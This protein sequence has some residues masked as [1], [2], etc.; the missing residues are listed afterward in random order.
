[1]RPQVSLGGIAV[2]CWEVLR[3]V[4]RF[5]SR[6]AFGNCS[7][8]LGPLLF[9]VVSALQGGRSHVALSMRHV[10]AFR[11][12]DGSDFANVPTD[13]AL[14]TMGTEHVRGRKGNISCRSGNKS[15]VMRFMLWTCRI[16]ACLP[17]RLKN[18]LCRYSSNSITL[19]IGWPRTR[20][21]LK[22]LCRRPM[23]R[24]CA[25]FPGFSWARTFGRGCFASSEIHSSPRGPG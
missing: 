17:Q 7:G 25:H 15:A 13:L 9:V 10:S 20:R 24:P 5:A 4:L 22:I 19:R 8:I 1:M 23:P 12:P 2:C 21:R 14:T 6:A 3:L 11:K 16:N 18:W